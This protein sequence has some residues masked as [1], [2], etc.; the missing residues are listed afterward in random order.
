MIRVLAT[1]TLL[2][3][4]LGNILSLSDLEIDALVD[5]YEFNGGP[6]WIRTA[7]VS[8]DR[9]LWNIE[10]LLDGSED[11]CQDN[12]LGIEC[13]CIDSY[14]HPFD[15]GYYYY[16][17][18]EANTTQSSCTITGLNL[19]FANVSGHLRSSF[20]NLRNLTTLHLPGNSLHGSILSL[21]IPHMPA[22]AII[23]LSG[24]EFTGTLPATITNMTQLHRL[25]LRNNYFSGTFPEGMDILDW[26][27]FDIRGNRFSGSVPPVYCGEHMHYLD[28]SFNQLTG[29]MP[30]NFSGDTIWYINMGTNSIDGTL[31]H[32][33]LVPQ[34]MSISVG[35]NLFTGSMHLDQL[36]ETII[37]FQISNTLCTGSIPS[38]INQA[39]QLRTL[40]FSNSLLSGSL[41]LEFTQLTE[42]RFVFLDNTTLSQSLPSTIGNMRQLKLLNIKHSGLQGPLPSSLTQMHALEAISAENNRFT[43]PLPSNWTSMQHL[44][45]VLLQ[46]NR[47]SG[48]IPLSLITLPEL[49]TLLLPNNRFTAFETPTYPMNTTTAGMRKLRIADFSLNLIQ[50]D[51][52][53]HELFTMNRETLYAFAL[54]RAC[55]APF[56]LSV[57]C[58][59]RTLEIVS[60]DGA[61]QA[62]VSTDG[63]SESLSE[64]VHRSQQLRD[65]NGLPRCLMELPYLRILHLSGLGL[66]GTIPSSSAAA[67]GPWTATAASPRLQDLSL[68]NNLLTGT[69]PS[70]I[71]HRAW[72]NVDLAFN[73]LSGTLTH[74]FPIT[75]HSQTRLQGNRLSGNLPVTFE[76]ATAI[77]VLDGNFFDCPLFNTQ[78]LP[79]QDP[80]HDIYSCG[81]NSLNVL[82]YAWHGALLMAVILTLVHVYR[83]QIWQQY[84][85]LASLGTGIVVVGQT[86]SRW[87]IWP[88]EPLQDGDEGHQQ[89]QQQQQ[90][91][92]SKQQQ[93]PREILRYV[94]R[95]LSVLCMR[96][97]CVATGILLPLCLVL[98]YIVIP[99]S[100]DRTYSTHSR[101]YAF[102]VSGVFLSG[103]SPGVVLAVVWLVSVGYFV[104]AVT[105]ICRRGIELC[106]LIDQ[107]HTMRHHH[108]RQKQRRRRQVIEISWLTLRNVVFP[109]HDRAF[110]LYVVGQALICIVI[111]A[112]FMGMNIGFIYAQVTYGPQVTVL[113]QI[114]LAVLD[115]LINHL[116][117]PWSMR[118][119]R[120]GTVPVPGPLTGGATDPSVARSP[121]PFPS[122]PPPPR[123]ET[124]VQPRRLLP[125]F[126]QR[127]NLLLTLWAT[128]VAPCIAVALY[129]SNCFYHAI[130][131]TPAVTTVYGLINCEAFLIYILVDRFEC[132]LE[133]TTWISISFRP[134]FVYSYG[135]SAYLVAS[136]TSVFVYSY[137]LECF[138]RPVSLYA[139]RQCQRYLLLPRWWLCRRSSSSINKSNAVVP[140]AAVASGGATAVSQLPQPQHSPKRITVQPRIIQ[141]QRISMQ[142]NHSQANGEVGDDK[143]AVLLAP[144]PSSSTAHRPSSIASLP[145]EYRSSSTFS[146]F[147][148]VP[149]L[150][151]LAQTSSQ[152][153][154]A[155]TR[156]CRVKGSNVIYRSWKGESLVRTIVQASA[157][158][159]SFGLVYPP[160]LVIVVVALSLSGV[161][162]TE[163]DSSFKEEETGITDL[164]TTKKTITEEVHVDINELMQ[165]LTTMESQLVWL[166]L[167]LSALFLSLAMFDAVGDVVGW[168]LALPVPVG[169]LG[170]LWVIV[171]ALRWFLQS[172]DVATDALN[173]QNPEIAAEEGG[174][175]HN[176]N[177]EGEEDDNEE[178]EEEEEEDNNE[179]LVEVVASLVAAIFAV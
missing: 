143:E 87:V 22:L 84:E 3:L 56:D 118:L 60:L 167:P 89:Q 38:S 162:T 160:L 27:A 99:T 1:I 68:S 131:E 116:F 55:I 170:L 44:R 40:I 105:C 130:F 13:S 166:V 81:T 146:V 98:H 63:K 23:G 109:G 79:T 140:V 24:N 77:N 7:H 114:G 80:K 29:P 95:C 78:T 30:C 144:T 61:N 157:V 172:K 21:I 124:I 138:F 145:P 121:I 69:I 43:G 161:F 126:E 147:A 4:L 163:D 73:K 14:S 50:G 9:Q 128:L 110:V 165:T 123:Q 92:S 150:R 74:S 175:I 28:I 32:F 42:L 41:P 88:T 5:F 37:S 132:T 96:M 15:Y 94:L 173:S 153:S 70:S 169:F 119:L 62:C 11:P 75:N 115:M 154:K 6:Y 148:T 57:I 106:H 86:V 46:N 97:G 20:S 71:Q 67:A 156:A 159:L 155:S 59:A 54:V 58:A 127:L 25:I 18:S 93:G 2:T 112:V 136:Y 47:L 19:P 139:V 35:P 179:T 158:M 49:D 177:E 85:G 168:V 82:L 107:N 31:P 36:P 117:F 151:L 72:E 64:M 134:S 104:Y 26:Y 135:C 113:C 164:S 125:L 48:T 176:D 102:E 171:Y 33:D 137:L 108:R 122:P 39:Y 53:V 152:W 34:L 52:P 17:E 149:I 178:E 8:S 111:A 103:I 51:I 66:S 133:R 90:Q 141:V 129:S 12:W 174:V 65:W 91:R 10:A 45:V 76:K 83:E 101:T 100:T 16:T 142:D 120:L